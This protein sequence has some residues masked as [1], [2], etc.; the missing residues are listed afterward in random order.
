MTVC[1]YLCVCDSDSV[2]SLSLPQTHISQPFS[3]CYGG[4]PSAHRRP[5]YHQFC[6][7]AFCTQWQAK[8]V[9]CL[10]SPPLSSPSLSLH[11]RLRLSILTLSPPLCLKACHS[12]ILF[13][14]HA[15]PCQW[16]MRE[17]ENYRTVC[18]FPELLKSALML[19][20]DHV[21][22]SAWAFRAHTQTHTHKFACEFKQKA[23]GGHNRTLVC[24]SVCVFVGVCIGSANAFA[25]SQSVHMEGTLVSHIS[26]HG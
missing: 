20:A 12:L 4:F 5:N 16:E 13:P 10:S 7:S 26:T 1:V 14:P 19:M 21:R 17:G 18:I 24:P 8:C 15:H 23:F 11:P 25:I 9:P 6:C 22:R 2:T 3:E